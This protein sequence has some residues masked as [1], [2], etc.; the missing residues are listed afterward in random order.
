MNELGTIVGQIIITMLSA[1]LVE[2]LVLSRFLGMCP[3]LGVT[4]KTSTAAGMGIAVAA[5]LMI[6]AALAWI[7][8]VTL[9]VPNNLEF[10]QTMSYILII[11]A[12]V[13]FLETVL[14][15]F[16]PPLYKALGIYLP[17]ITTNCAVLGIPLINTQRGYDFGMTLVYTLGAGLGFA[18]A[19]VLFSGVRER[20]AKSDIPASL[21]GVSGALFAATLVSMSFFGFQGL[22]AK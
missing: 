12:V 5:V 16:I 21:Q 11:A 20:M 14:R 17:L 22:F 15:K 10:L 1:I 2:N 4:Q 6:V 7:V 9:L 3:F 18:M 13:Q 19:L 8:N